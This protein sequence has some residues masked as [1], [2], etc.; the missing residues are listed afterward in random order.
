[1]AFSDWDASEGHRSASGD[2]NESRVHRR[3]PQKVDYS[4][5]DLKSLASAVDFLVVDAGRRRAT[6]TPVPRR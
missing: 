2:G 4:T 1:V 5:C 6:S 3:K